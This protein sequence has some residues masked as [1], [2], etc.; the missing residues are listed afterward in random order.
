MNKKAKIFFLPI[1]TRSKEFPPLLKM[2]GKFWHTGIIYNGKV[3]ECFNFGKNSISDFN[4]EFKNKLE[5]QKAVFIDTKINLEKL[6]SEIISG[7]DCS[8]YV[9]RVIG[10]SK[11]IGSV[12]I[13]WPEEVYNYI[14]KIKKIFWII[15]FKI[16][17]VVVVVGWVIFAYPSFRTEQ[18]SPCGPYE[19]KNLQIGERI[20]KVDISDNDCKRVQGLSDRKDM[21]ENNGMLFIFDKKGNYLFWM[22]EMNFPIDILWVD[23]NFNVVG[24]ETSV[25]TST[26]PE[27]FGEK[28]LARYVLESPSGFSDKNNIKV[29]NKISF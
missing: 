14:L 7:T 2:V 16:L 17:F 18:K 1:E 5:N 20:I 13:F 3:Y 4:K 19:Q 29:G 24:I 26:Y 21:S 8:E 10:L 23:D 9:A 22:K 6:N 15:N 12:K 25:A 11:N 27:A 28:Y